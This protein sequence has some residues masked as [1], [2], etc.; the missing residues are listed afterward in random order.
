MAFSLFSAIPV[1]TIDVFRLEN[2]ILNPLPYF[3]LDLRKEES[4]HRLLKGSV[5]VSEK[6]VFA[7]KVPTWS[8]KNHPIILICD[9]GILST[10]VGRKLIQLQFVNVYVV[11]GGFKSLN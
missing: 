10:R 8:D 2:L 9:D 7:E 5:R 1:P 11:E 4:H 6:Q 3:Y